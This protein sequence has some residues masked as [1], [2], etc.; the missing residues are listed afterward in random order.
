MG[1]G[2]VQIYKLVAVDGLRQGGKI[3]TNLLHIKGLLHL[4]PV[5]HLRHRFLFRIR[6][7]MIADKR[8]S[9][10]TVLISANSAGVM[11]T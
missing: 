2:I 1:C 5:L 10:E 11:E 9:S 7:L 4:L 3:P 8:A 6:L